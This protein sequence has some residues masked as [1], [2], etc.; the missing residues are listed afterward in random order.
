[1]PAP[2]SCSPTKQLGA[3]LEPDKQDK[4]CFEVR[5]YRLAVR[6]D[7]GGGLCGVHNVYRLVCIAAT[8]ATT[9]NLFATQQ[10]AGETLT[11]K[12][13]PVDITSETT[14]QE[15]IAP[16]KDVE[17]WFPGYFNKYFLTGMG[18]K[19]TSGNWIRAV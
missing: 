6:R 8:T 14:L 7:G 19:G 3:Y 13:F 4:T 5:T 1:M 2:T 17:K 18:Y 10:G 15:L 16:S 12:G 11:R 9:T